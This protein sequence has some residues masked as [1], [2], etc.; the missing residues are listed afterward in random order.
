MKQKLQSH[1]DILLILTTIGFFVMLLI[2]AIK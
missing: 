1:A 2:D